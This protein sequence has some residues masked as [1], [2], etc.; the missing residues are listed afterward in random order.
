MSPAAKTAGFFA[1][2]EIENEIMS[3]AAIGLDNRSFMSIT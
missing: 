1:L 2:R 3:I